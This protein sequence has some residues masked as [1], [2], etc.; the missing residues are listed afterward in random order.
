MKLGH[1]LDEDTQMGPV[2]SERQ[3]ET[4]TNYIDIG[5]SEGAEVVTGGERETSLGDGYYV[6]PTIFAGVSN[7]M[8]IAQEEIFGPVATVIEVTDV[9]HAIEVANDTMYGLVANVHTENVRRAH[10]VA[11]A[12]ECGTVFVNL[13]PVPFTEAPIGGYKQTGVGKDLGRHALDEYLLTKSVLIDLS[14][15][16]RH[17]RW[18]QTN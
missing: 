15:P 8:R 1:A 6:Q 11:G 7:D 2:V 13:P 9:D 12:L 4:V 18:F 17:F 3:L 16:G 14:E 5:K 10:T